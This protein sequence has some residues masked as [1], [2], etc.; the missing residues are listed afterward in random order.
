MLSLFCRLVLEGNC[1]RVCCT[2]H[3]PDWTAP[4]H[5]PPHPLSHCQCYAPTCINPTNSRLWKQMPSSMLEKSL[6][7]TEPSLVPARTAVTVHKGKVL[8][9]QQ[10]QQQQKRCEIS[11]WRKL[12]ERL[13][14]WTCQTVSYVVTADS[15]TSNT[16]KSDTELF[17]QVAY[18]ISCTSSPAFSC[19][20][21]FSYQ[22]ASF[23]LWPLQNYLSSFVQYAL[24]PAINRRQRRAEF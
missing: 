19:F 17:G 10:K 20:L 21:F 23:Q 5:T 11:D 14:S 22:W 1:I 4:R 15:V 9:C 12:T 18:S 3:C 24:K 7:H 16:F 2:A 8:S 13:S 6:M